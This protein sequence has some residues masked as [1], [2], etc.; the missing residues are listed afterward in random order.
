MKLI[1]GGFSY[2]NEIDFADQSLSRLVVFSN[3]KWTV[4]TGLLVCP[5][6]FYHFNTSMNTCYRDGVSSISTYIYKSATNYTIITYN[7]TFN[8]DYI[9][10]FYS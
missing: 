1:N 4:D 10:Q 8:S 7:L 9:S 6:G 5:L 3:T 2:A